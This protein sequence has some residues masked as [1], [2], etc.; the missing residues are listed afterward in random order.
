MHHLAIISGPIAAHSNREPLFVLH[1]LPLLVPFVT[2]FVATLR[3]LPRFQFKRAS[4]A[5]GF[6]TRS[7][8]TL[9][10]FAAQT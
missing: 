9:V 8:K 5:W 7:R 1:K 10:S 3:R 4:Y 6:F 2:Q